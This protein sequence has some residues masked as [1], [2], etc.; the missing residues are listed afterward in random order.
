[1]TEVHESAFI[2]SS[3][4][5]A[6][7]EIVNLT[8]PSL[9]AYVSVVRLTVSAMASRC[10]FDIESIEDIKVAITEAVTNAVVHTSSNNSSKI[11]IES[12]FNYL[13]KQ[14]TIKIEDQG[15]GFDSSHIK[16]PDISKLQSGGLGLF[17]IRSLMDEVNLDTTVGQGTSIVMMKKLGGK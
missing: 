15:P 17:I 1:M 12:S 16:I 11:N 2:D 7:N 3:V 4:D 13:S 5:M 9:P 14:L 10:G 6:L 8:V